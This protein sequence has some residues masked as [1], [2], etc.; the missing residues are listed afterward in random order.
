MIPTQT[1]KCNSKVAPSSV[2]KKEKISRRP[3]EEGIIKCLVK[4]KRLK[5]HYKW[6]AKSERKS[7]SN[8]D[9]TQKSFQMRMQSQW[10]IKSPNNGD[11]K[12]QK[13]IPNGNTESD[14]NDLRTKA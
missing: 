9:K 6:N 12:T 2:T 8:G 10:K 4:A 14:S 11:K 13:V 1:C 5:S 7:P 3:L